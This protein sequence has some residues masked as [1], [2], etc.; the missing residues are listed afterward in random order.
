MTGWLRRLLEPQGSQAGVRGEQKACARPWPGIG[1]SPSRQALPGTLRWPLRSLT[2]QV[3]HL[4]CLLV[5]TWQH[6][7][8]DDP[9]G[10]LHLWACWVL[11]HQ[12]FFAGLG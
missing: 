5:N 8:P 7:R 9:A 11:A 3:R 6:P 4:P 10:E 12:S 1:R 2:A